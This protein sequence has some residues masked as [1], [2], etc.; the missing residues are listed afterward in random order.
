MAYIGNT[1]AENYASFE[2]E[3][4]TVSAT[5]NYTLS[6]AVANENE[7]RLVINGVV[8][9]PGS[10]KA[11]TASGTTLTLSSATASGDSMYA[12]YLGR[13]LQTV[14]PPAASVGNSQTAPTIITG[15]TAETSIATDDTILIHDTSASALRKM[16]RA[17]FVSGIGGTNTPAFFASISSDQSISNNSTTLVALATKVLDT[18]SAFNNTASNY[19]FTVPEAGNYQINFGIRNS[20]FTAARIDVQVKK[21]GNEIVNAENASGGNYDTAYGGAILNLSVGDYLQMYVYQTSGSSQNIFSARNS[22]FMSG[23]KLI[24]V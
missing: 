24:G 12:V 11:Y 19:K 14:N 23:Y 18:D 1:P 13:A 3:T 4:F 17:N 6:H 9:Q 22:C 8:Q 21:N 7:I 15:Q 5:T 20:N 2:T 10:G 16:T